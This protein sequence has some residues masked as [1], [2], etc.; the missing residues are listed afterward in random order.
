MK[1]IQV[2][3]NIDFDIDAN[4]DNFNYNDI[5]AQKVKGHIIVRNGILSIND[6]AMNILNGTI[7]M[8]ADYDTRDTLKP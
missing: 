1:L 2:P 6:A 8:N 5:K 7:T 3:K 4:I